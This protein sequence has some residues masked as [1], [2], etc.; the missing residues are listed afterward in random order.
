MP[1]DD[2]ILAEMRQQSSLWERAGDQRSVFLGCYALMTANMLLALQQAEF[3][4]PVWVGQLLRRFAGYYFD[5]LKAYDQAPT[6][7][8]TVWQLAFDTCRQEQADVLQHLMLGVNAHINY[9]LVLTLVDMLDTEWKTLS[10]EERSQR[11]ADHCHVNEVIGRTIDAVQDT[12]LEARQPSL[13]WVDRAFG[14]LDERLIS[15]LISRWRDQVWRQAEQMLEVYPPER[16]AELRHAVESETL[17]RG[18][19]ILNPL[20]P[21]GSD[22][23]W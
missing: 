14:T 8:P 5:A 18:A 3:H 22:D 9:D 10:A 4:D 11:Y 17:R 12:I 23:V 2:P 21:R 1:N 19:A 20:D 16:R 7:S 6:E 15:G 13:D